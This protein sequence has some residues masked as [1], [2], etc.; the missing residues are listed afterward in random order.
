M[1]APTPLLVSR[2]ARVREALGRA[3]LEAL[4]VTKLPNVAYLTNLSASAAAAVVTRAQLYLITD[5]RYSA[6]VHRLLSSPEAPPDAVF[7][8]VEGSYD[9]AIADVVATLAPARCGFEAAHVPVRQH[10]TWE[11]RLAERSVPVEFVSTD[12][13]IE[14]VRVV[15]DAFEERILREAAVRLSDVARGVLQD[16]TKAGRTERDLAAEIDWRIKR[17]GFDRTAFDTIVAAGP[18]SALPHAHP[19]D[20]RV[21]SGELLLFDFGGVFHGYCVDLTRTV[22]VGP[23]QEE[24]RRVY[25]AVYEAQRAAIAA[26]RSGA[27]SD[28]VDA[29]ARDFLTVQGLGE[30]FGHSTG[31]GLGLEVHEDP[32]LAK[33]RDGGP[34]PMT[35][36]RGMVCTI[37]PGAYLPDWGGVRLEDDVWVDAERCEL[38]TEVPF[39][40]RL[41]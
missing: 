30:A 15:K 39:D 27:T 37:E 25:R 38:L 41:M 32:R 21:E 34:S 10:R 2:L 4:V 13:L 40:E 18:N 26:V 31:H 28:Q 14:G 8:Q 12:A 1:L 29:A 22:V 35:L 36:E 5:F 7:H 16:L 24:Q 9:E 17:A 11:H 3:Q 33:R 23:V 19:T 20:R 6:A